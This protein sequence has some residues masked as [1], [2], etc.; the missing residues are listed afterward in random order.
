M[1]SLAVGSERVSTVV[2]YML[3][4]G[5]FSQTSPNL[6]QRIAVIGEA[7]TTHQSGLSTIP[8]EI[9]SLKQAGELYGF[10]SPIHSVLRILKPI[11]GDGVGGIPVVVYPQAA[12]SGAAAKVLT[13]TVTGTATGNGTHTLVVAGRRSLDGSNYD[14]NIVA[15]DTPTDIADKIAD[16]INNVLGAPATASSSTGV[17]TVTAKWAG[18]TSQGLN[19]TVDN[20]GNGLGVTYAVAQT[21]AGSGTPSIPTDIFGAEWNTIVIN[22]YGTASNA[23]STLEQINGRPDQ[24]APTGRYSGIIMKPFI[25]L[26]GSVEND[27]TSVTDPRKGECTI[28]ICPAPGSA[29]FQFEA[30]ANMCVLFA[31][32]AQD[33]PHLDVSGMY[34]PD[35]PTPT[36][37]GAMAA[38]NTRDNFVKKG[39]STVDVVS[40]RYEVKDF[41]T[42][43]HPVGE[44]PPQFRYCRNLMLD[45]NVRFGYYLLE[46]R[47]VVG[48]AIAADSDVVSAS[49]VV[50]PKQWKQIVSQ[51]AVDLGTRALIADVEFMRSNIQVTINTTNPD[52]LDT[53][54]KYKRTGTARIAATT[55]E[56]G[57]N[58]GALN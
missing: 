13:I 47:Y 20:N 43:Y 32:L 44:E 8:T 25:A 51:Y 9:T 45:F 46:Q 58:F 17:A 48:H 34:Y 54:F 1:N 15:G 11:S 4:K 35:M 26:T 53:N 2:G 5:D 18:L 19:I 22:T 41:V 21:T 27:P 52:R 38:Y 14:V 57:F 42:T 37:A 31:R 24:L 30:A 55:A 6:P 36:T 23:L 50:K 28:A 10:G 16:A 12:A 40:G 29:G 3:T 39:C 33:S 49:N 7:N 56:A